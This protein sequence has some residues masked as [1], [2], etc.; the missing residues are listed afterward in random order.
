[1]K[2]ARKRKHQRIDGLY[3]KIKAYSKSFL[4]TLTLV[5]VDSKMFPFS[6]KSA[7]FDVLKRLSKLLCNLLLKGNVLVLS[8]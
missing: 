3:Y 4:I 2:S 1:M 8:F 6:T 5:W 7:V